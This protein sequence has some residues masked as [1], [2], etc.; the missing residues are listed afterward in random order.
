MKQKDK[1]AN[2]SNIKRFDTSYKGLIY[3]SEKVQVH[4]SLFLDQDILVGH[5]LVTPKNGKPSFMRRTGP[6]PQNKYHNS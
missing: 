4:E 5:E 1:K 2:R 6:L 3:R